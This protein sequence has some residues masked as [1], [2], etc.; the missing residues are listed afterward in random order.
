M[1]PGMGPGMGGMPGGMGGGFGWGDMEKKD[2]E[3]FKLLKADMDLERQTRELAM[4]YRQTSSDGRA[5]IKEKVKELV[6]KHFDVRQQRRAL[7]LKRLEAELQ[8]LR[9]TMERRLKARDK[10][11]TDR[12]SDLLGRED[13]AS[14]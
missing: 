13:E 5:K 4:Q 10:L 14:F 2:P 11:V 12:V 8:R 1:M 6:A 7:E 9:E 3:M